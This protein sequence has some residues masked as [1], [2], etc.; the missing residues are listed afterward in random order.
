MTGA[1]PRL[2]WQIFIGTHTSPLLR[3]HLRTAVKGVSEAHVMASPRSLFKARQVLWSAGGGGL[4]L[5]RQ[6]TVASFQITP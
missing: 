2:P 1:R 6:A 5:I 3:L 4:I